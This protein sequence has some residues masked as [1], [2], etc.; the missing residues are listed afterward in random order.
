MAVQADRVRTASTRKLAFAIAAGVPAAAASARWAPWQA[1]VMVT[2]L[3][4]IGAWLAQVWRETLPYSAEHTRLHATHEDERGAA[5]LL[6]ITAAAVLSLA[7]GVAAIVKGRQDGG[8]VEVAM[9]VLAVAAVAA[10]WLAIQTVFM[11]HYASRYYE[12][13][14]GGIDF[15]GEEPPAYADFAYVAVALGVAFA[16]S[17]TDLTTRRVRRVALQHMLVS[18]VFGAIIVGLTIN[19]LAGLAG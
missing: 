5:A 1:A 9:T 13:P 10:S 7:G 17:D 15:H 8:G 18:Y 2:W 12:E 6:L 3:V 4:A 19:I 16:V 11:L 14:V